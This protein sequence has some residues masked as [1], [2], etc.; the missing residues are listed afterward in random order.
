MTEG[1]PN[2]PLLTD[3][4]QLTMM[5]AYLERGMTETAVFEF[6]VRKLPETRRFLLAAGLAQVVEFLRELRFSDSDLAWLER[7]GHADE[8]L[9]D[10]LAGLRFGGD[11]DAM[12][13]GSVFFAD[14]P[15]LRITAPL[16]VA[17]LIESRIINLL[18]FET[19]IASKA[20]R[21]RLAAADQLLV[22]FGM[23]RAHGAEA[24]ML[25]AR[26]AYL[27]G[28]EGSATVLAGK[29]FGIPLYGTMA[30]S[31]VL[32]HDD[33]L[34]AFE[35]FARVHP[36]K[37]VLLIDTYDTLDGAHK[38]VEVAARLRDAGIKVR[39]VRLDSGDLD[40]LS[41]EVRGILDA[42]GLRDV[43]IF[44]SGNLDEYAV[45]ALRA[46][47]APVDGFGV[48][49]RMD[50]SSDAPYLDCAYKLQ[51]YADRARR[52]RSEGKATWPGRKQVYRRYDANGL[53][54]GDCI[55]LENAPV[56]GEPLLQPVMRGGELI[57][58]LTNLEES[59]EYALAQ[60]GRLP[61]ALRELAPRP[62]PYPVEIGAELDALAR[63]LDSAA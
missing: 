39:G 5:Q 27:A 60:L 33:E 22:D 36:D 18:H 58:P 46:G 59:R 45:Q 35:D 51:E 49:T 25:A 10:Y 57:A 62:S 1:V 63:R 20:A 29:E 30:H 21:I 28:F 44:A 56:Q 13:E 34:G 42:A 40:A 54:E 19:L 2:S 53:M 31:F 48:G 24:G 26:A 38:V 4:Y 23:R 17:Q 37:T 55:T 15:I 52:K 43:T 50:V 32:A 3:L 41:R 7:S 8:R 61:P 16:P 11:V 9:L 47:G 6:F 14:E 12:R